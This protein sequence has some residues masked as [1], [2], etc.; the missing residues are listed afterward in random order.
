MWWRRHLD[1]NLG[2]GSAHSMNIF[3]IGSSEGTDGE[4]V[5]AARKRRGARQEAHINRVPAIKWQRCPVSAT[6]YA[7][8]VELIGGN[9]IHWNKAE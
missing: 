9:G 8:H 1:P 7:E 5:P 6:E 4:A 3:P 2:E